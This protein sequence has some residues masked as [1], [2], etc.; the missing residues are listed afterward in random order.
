MEETLNHKEE[1]GRYARDVLHETSTSAS[2]GVRWWRVNFVLPR[3]YVR[4]LYVT[5]GL[6]A[7]SFLA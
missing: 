1:A 6:L 4:V 2:E 5:S 3:L 7:L